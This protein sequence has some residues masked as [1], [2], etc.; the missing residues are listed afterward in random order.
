[1]AA[2]TKNVALYFHVDAHRVESA[3]T[4]ASVHIPL[5]RREMARF[6][7]RFHPSGARITIW[8]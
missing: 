7:Y 8:R 6:V 5:T 4:R 1:L 2:M 3:N